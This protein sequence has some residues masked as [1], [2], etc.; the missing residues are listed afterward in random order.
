MVY[1]QGADGRVQWTD[2][3]NYSAIGQVEEFEAGARGRR[4]TSEGIGN[5]WTNFG[6]VIDPQPSWR[7][8]MAPV[9]WNFIPTYCVV[10][11]QGTP[12]AF[13]LRY[14]DGQEYGH[15]DN[16]YVDT[17]NMEFAH[18][19]PGVCNINGGADNISGNAGTYTFIASPATPAMSFRQISTLSIFGTS[20]L[21]DF[22]TASIQI[23]NNM[24]FDFAGNQLAPG[25]TL[26]GKVGYRGRIE[27]AKKANAPYG[28]VMNASQGT[29]VYAI[30]DRAAAP[31]TKTFTFNNC[32]L[33]EN[34][35]QMPM[36]LVV[37]RVDWESGHLVIT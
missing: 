26:P 36:D 24:I 28:N 33:V 16:C 11:A 14:F 5:R 9:D 31:T 15:L 17:L 22:R 21:T 37:T 12:A 18:G 35:V 27:W 34:T 20:I 1:F 2:E 29:I 3:T 6:R 8:R 13:D 30:A 4:I 10:T 23:D 25:D 32:D 19:R 7:I